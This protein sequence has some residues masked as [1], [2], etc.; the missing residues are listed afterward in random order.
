MVIKASTAS[1]VRQ[2]VA[3][4]SSDDAVKR[5][6]A[7]ARLAIIGPRAIDRLLAVYETSD[8]ETRVAILRAFEAVGDRRS[9]ALAR[10]ALAEAGTIAAAAVGALR[11]QLDSPEASLAGDALDALVAS[12][13]DTTADRA[14]R[15]LAFDALQ[16]MPENVRARVAAALREDP[17]PKIRTRVT[18]APRE[19]ALADAAWE[20]ALEGTVG[21]DPALLRD[22]LQT[23]GASAAFSTLQR[24]VDAVRAKEATVRSTARRDPWISLRG[25]LH[26]TL[27]FRGSHIALY[28]LRETFAATTTPLP[29]SFLSA[30][31]V[32]GDPSCVDPLGAAY[33][34]V[35]DERWRGQVA[36]AINGIARRHRISRR[37]TAM[38]RMATRWPEAFAALSRKR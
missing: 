31:A 15:L 22:A 11:G 16:I 32:V 23:R 7:L 33:T 13:L 36:S 20:D 10:R 21:D 24:L 18:D 29:V 28:D 30:V 26:Q 2:L 8:A 17:D 25:A 6:S 1:E 9:V 4:L 12:A 14:L 37:H 19:A 34:N 27:A 35:R 3:A 5:E 38:K